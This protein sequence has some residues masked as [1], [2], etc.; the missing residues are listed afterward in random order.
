MNSAEPGAVLGVTIPK[1]PVSAPLQGPSAQG[2]FASPAGA[3]AEQSPL[4][5]SPSSDWRLRM[6]GVR[7][8][9]AAAA[10]AALR[11]GDGAPVLG[12]GSRLS[13]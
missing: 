9:P 12:L 13:S 3:I 6:A 5:P 10:P 1:S 7:A 8:P 2:W 11:G 4:C